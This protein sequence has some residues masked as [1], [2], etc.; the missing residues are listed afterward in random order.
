MTL[1]RDQRDRQRAYDGVVRK[2]LAVTCA[3]C[4]GDGRW[5]KV[6]NFP[7]FPCDGSGDVLETEQERD[8]RVEDELDAIQYGPSWDE[9]HGRI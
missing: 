2:R 4:N 6:D 3:K 1:T 5:R 7:C 9:L 8:A